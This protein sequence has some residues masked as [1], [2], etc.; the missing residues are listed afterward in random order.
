MF[1]YDFEHSAGTGFSRNA[2]WHDGAESHQTGAA[3][4]PLC[5]PA[6]HAVLELVPLPAPHPRRYFG[7]Y[8]SG[9]L[10]IL[11]SFICLQALDALTTLLFLRHGIAE[12]NPLI[13]AALTGAADPKIALALA[14]ILAIALGTLAWRSGRKRLLWRMNVL[15]ALCV[16]WNLVAAWVGHAA[17][18]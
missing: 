14:K 15:F 17:G 1:F 9:H 11:F 6:Y 8:E 7:L 16:A 4:L 12:A 5:L 13:R 3:K 2:F 18:A 10:V